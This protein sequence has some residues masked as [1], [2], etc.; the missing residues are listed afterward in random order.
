MAKLL[1]ERIGGSPLLTIF[2]AGAT[3][4]IEE[5]LLAGLIGDA[6]VL[7]G[8]VKLFLGGW[9]IPY[10]AGQH[11]SNNIVNGISLGF[12]IDGVEDIIRGLFFGGGIWNGGSLF[13]GNKQGDTI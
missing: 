13:G 2:V 12:G 7:S 4:A 10:F 3:K 6:T 8:A 9:L 11:K 5:P 1:K